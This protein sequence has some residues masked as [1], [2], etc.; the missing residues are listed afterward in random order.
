M[1]KRK[2]IME[3]NGLPEISV[4]TDTNLWNTSLTSCPS[5]WR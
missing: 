1:T 5:L 3:H 2:E 4:Y